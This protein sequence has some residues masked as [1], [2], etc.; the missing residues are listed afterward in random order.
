MHGVSS[1]CYTHLEEIGANIHHRH[2]SDNS[3]VR[4]HHDMA[5][6]IYRDP[7]VQGCITWTR[8]YLAGAVIQH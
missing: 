5:A 3:T 2:D 1:S 4:D 6:D 7:D 8:A